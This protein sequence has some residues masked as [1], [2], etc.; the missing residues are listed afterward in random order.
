MYNIEQVE[1]LLGTRDPVESPQPVASV[2]QDGSQ[3]NTFS[4]VPNISLADASAVTMPD[5]MT[6]T[7]GYADPSM[8]NMMNDF[9]LNTSD[10]FSWEMI[11]LGLEEPLPN[12]DI[13]DEMYDF[14]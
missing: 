9:G 4:E 5:M 14:Y 8:G 1:T 3:A 7:P 13:V 10:E 2:L 6:T 12:Q 11:G